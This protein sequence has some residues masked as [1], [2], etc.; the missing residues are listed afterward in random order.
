MGIKPTCKLSARGLETVEQ[1]R[2]QKD[3]DRQDARW[4][5]SA[6][7]SHA[8]LKRFWR[9]KPILRESFIKLCDVVDVDWEDV[10]DENFTGEVVTEET[11]NKTS[12]QQPASIVPY[13]AYGNC[14]VGRE[15]L[16]TELSAVVL[17]GCRVLSIAGITG[18]GKSCLA[19]RM[20][21]ELQ[22]DYP[23]IFYINFDDE[24]QLTD[25]A[26]VAIE[27]LRGWNET[28]TN[29][30]QQDPQRLLRRVV[31]YLQEHRCLVLIDSLERVLEGD[32]EKGYSYFQDNCWEQFFQSLLASATSCPSC[33]ILT[34]QDRPDQLEAIGSR[35]EP[36]YHSLDLEGLTELEQL[37]L[38]HQTGLAVEPE[39][40]GRPYLQTIGRAYEGHP[41]ALLVTAGEVLNEPFRGNVIAYWKK[42]GKE[43]ETVM[44][45]RPPIKPKSQAEAISPNDQFKLDLS[46]RRKLEQK[47]R[48][49]IEKTFS[50]LAKDIFN[51]YL[52]LC[53][54]SVYRRPV[55]E[56]WWL[57]HLEECTLEE[58][59]AALTALCDRYLVEE[60]LTE[61]EVLMRQHNLIRSVAL[62]HLKTLTTQEQSA[63]FSATQ[64]QPA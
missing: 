22:N 44:Q 33:L 64:E 58:Q 9:S 41:L 18:V 47:V 12:Q 27:L 14:W 50:R 45:E 52:L 10:A 8:T 3:W 49:R 15:A 56:E 24:Q 51:A 59:D 53:E 26:S 13:L 32:E 39:A 31:K 35:N 37:E 28:I 1:A 29:Q 46:N 20:M 19:K 6:F 2:I 38:F 34:T 42:Y 23:A 7:C 4:Y 63:K 40:P 16:I 62:T 55:P 30:D 21:I 61:D 36:F 60:E 17:G 48:Q 5:N 54:T 25:F 11:P 57:E 43:I